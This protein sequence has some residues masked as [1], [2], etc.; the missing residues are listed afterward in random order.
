MNKNCSLLLSKILLEK[1]IEIFFENFC[2][3]DTF[4]FPAKSVKGNLRKKKK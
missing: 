3:N 4:W 1:K 2:S